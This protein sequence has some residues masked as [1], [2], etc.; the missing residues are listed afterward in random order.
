[1]AAK[2][3]KQLIQLGCLSFRVLDPCVEGKI[4]MV[5]A[6]PILH[7]AAD[8][9]EGGVTVRRIADNLGKSEPEILGY[10]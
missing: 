7:Q 6:R 8:R 3:G 1:M 2:I 9:L 4:P 10:R 5:K